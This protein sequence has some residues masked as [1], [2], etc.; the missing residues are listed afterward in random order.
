MSSSNFVVN[1]TIP[2]QTLSHEEYS[3]RAISPR[4]RGS[5]VSVQSLVAP[6]SRRTKGP[7]LDEPGFHVLREHLIDYPTGENLN[8]LWGFGSMAGICL[9][10]QILTGIFL[11]MHYPASTRLAFEAV[12]Q[13]MMRDVNF[14]WLLRYF[15]ANGAS[16]FFIVVYRHIFRGFY[17][18]SYTAPRELVWLSGIRILLVMIITAF[19]GYVLPW[20]QMSF[21]GATVITSLASAIPRAGPSIV[22]W[23]WG[24]FLV[25]NVTLN[26]FFRLHFVLPFVIAGLAGVHLA[27]LHQYGSTNPI[28]SV[29]ESR[30]VT[31]YPYYFRKDLVAWLIFRIAFSFFVFF[32][33]NAMG[34]PD[35]SI[36]ANPLSTPAH[37]Q[38][39]W[40]FLPVYAILRSIPDKLGGVLRIGRVFAR[41]RYLP[42]GQTGTFRHGNFR[43]FH[44][45]LFRRFAGICFF[46]GW[47]GAKPVESPYLEFGQVAGRLFFLY[48]YLQVVMAQ[49]ERGFPRYLLSKKLVFPRTCWEHHLSV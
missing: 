42:F 16:F 19:L 32:E 39:E 11:R 25:D 34:H 27:A 26:R 17:Y 37:I 45:R 9:G 47:I 43:M 44:K 38:P 31:L 8:D 41:M 22:E 33:P 49:L 10:V 48:F 23:L 24:G 3:E 40:Y 5:A 15:H 4:L 46:L 7:I 20:G 12:E 14:G 36:P 21:W 28:G 29:V 30:K 35:N 18:S 13:H 1:Y 6:S 2:N